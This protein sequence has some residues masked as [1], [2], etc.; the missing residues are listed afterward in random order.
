MIIINYISGS[1]RYILF[2]LLQIVSNKIRNEG[3]SINVSCEP[4]NWYTSVIHYN[5]IKVKYK[6][7]M[8]S[9]I[10]ADVSHVGIYIKTTN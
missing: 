6:T 2:Y 8:K 5:Q 4:N 1:A 3:I 9:W 10:K 7:R